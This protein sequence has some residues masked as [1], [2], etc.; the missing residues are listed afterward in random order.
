MD[1]KNTIVAITYL[2]IILISVFLGLYY[3]IG[4]KREF[5]YLI[6]LLILTFLVEFTSYTKLLIDNKAISWLYV[7]FLPAQYVLLALY[8]K[9]IIKSTKIKKWIVVS[10]ATLII[11]NI[12]NSIFLQNLKMINTNAI[13]LA[14]ILYCIWSIVYFIE[15]LQNDTDE[16]LSK[17]PHFWINTGTLFFYASSF[18]IIEFIQII[19]K[20]DK[21]L[22]AKLWFLIR[23]F[24]IILYGLYAYGIICQAK[25]Q[26]SSILR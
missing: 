1:S 2:L 9:R 25:Y 16:P 26:N 15:L 21:E 18:F 17:N 23:L 19:L 6:T 7:F 14:C 11:W 24:D 22:A 5:Y 12:Y 20:G 13:L 8:F 10:I 3:K 4:V